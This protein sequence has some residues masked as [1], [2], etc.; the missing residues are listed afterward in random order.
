V[1]LVLPTQSPAILPQSGAMPVRSLERQALAQEF[2]AFAMIC[3][4]LRLGSFTTKAGRISPYFFN[5]GLFDEGAKLNQLAQF[6]GRALELDGVDFD[7]IFGPAYKGIPLAIALALHLSTK[8]QSVPFVFNRKESK[9]H[10]EGGQFVGASIAGRVLIVDDVVSAGTASSQ[11]VAAITQAG[12]KAHALIVALDR[13]EKARQD[14]VDLPFSALQHAERQWGL[15]VC[16]IATLSDLIAYLT[17]NPTA[18]FEQHREAMLAYQAQYGLG[19]GLC[20]T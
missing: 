10:G 9:T 16:A 18:A 12:G 8:G 3:G 5:A 15:K 2:V 13:Q 4:A 6:Y 7:M 20:S 14:G 1:S 17:N 11:S 19:M